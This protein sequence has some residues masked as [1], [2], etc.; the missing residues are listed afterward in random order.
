MASSK[1]SDKERELRYLRRENKKEQEESRRNAAE[2]RA[3][4]AAKE[5][6]LKA[7]KGKEGEVRKTQSELLASYRSLNQGEGSTERLP[8]SARR[9]ERDSLNISFERR[10]EDRSSLDESFTTVDRSGIIYRSQDRETQQIHTEDNALR[11]KEKTAKARRIVFSSE[12]RKR[13]SETDDSTYDKGSPYESDFGKRLNMKQN[14]L[15]RRANESIQKEDTTVSLSEQRLFP[16]EQHKDNMNNSAE[17]RLHDGREHDGVRK[18]EAT[19]KKTVSP[20]KYERTM[21]HTRDLRDRIRIENRQTTED[22]DTDEDLGYRKGFR[23]HLGFGTNGL[24]NMGS[25]AN[26][27]STERKSQIDRKRWSDERKTIDPPSFILE[28]WKTDY[29]DSISSQDMQS[30][31]MASIL[32][33]IRIQNREILSEERKR[34]EDSW[35]S[36]EEEAKLK[37]EKF[38]SEQQ[39]KMETYFAA[40]EAEIVRRENELKQREDVIRQHEEGLREANALKVAM[41]NREEELK[42]K[43][44]SLIEREEWIGQEERTIQEMNSLKDSLLEEKEEVKR[45]LELVN[46]LDIQ[47]KEKEG[48]LDQIAAEQERMSARREL[49]LEDR[50]VRTVSG[51]QHEIEQDIP[52]IRDLK[53]VRMK[54]ETEDTIPKM[55]TDPVQPE[56]Q[57]ETS[58]QADKMES[59]CNRATGTNE[60]RQT[61]IDAQC[62]Y[63]K[64][65]PFSVDDPKPRTE[66]SYEEW[67]YEVECTRKEKEHT[68]TTIVQSIRKSLRGRAK[69]VILTLGTAAKIEDIMDK[70]ENEFGNVASGQTIM[71]EF[72]TA[73]QKETESVNEWGLRLEEIFQRAIEKGK[74]REVERD[75]TLREQFWKSL[76]SERLKNATRVKYESLKSFE[77]LRKAVRAEENEMKLATNIAQQQARTQ[78]KSEKTETVQEEKEDKLDLILKRIEALERGRNRGGY[79]GGYRGRYNQRR[80]Q[81]QNQGNRQPEKKEQNLTKEEKSEETEVKK[82]LKD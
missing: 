62:F 75:T 38:F 25:R 77:Q 59:K 10:S 36:R 52:L 78:I 56:L 54:V 57:H 7:L 63:P 46:K 43:E 73:T 14:I 81:Y 19:Y 11:K 76:R 71:K 47:L 3:L 72:Y 70:L 51:I 35:T 55:V 50:K 48:H 53:T 4:Q 74:A 5:E 82:P 44:E 58:A 37:S 49:E 26:E 32:E 23:Q 45:K 6:F 24:E 33:E 60:I 41:L 13:N 21:E 79:R 16:H 40:R 39:K 18:K 9:Q 64:F 31:M 15:Q 42:R 65:S 66:A 20:S 29:R 34:I 12:N 61:V 30:Q 1:E 80:G 17:D 8:G 67:K 22:S 2:V 69:R 68:D 27:S 28:D